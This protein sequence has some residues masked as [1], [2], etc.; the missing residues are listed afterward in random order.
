MVFLGIFFVVFITFL[1]VVH[2]F[3]ISIDTFSEP[4]ESPFIIPERYISYVT[5]IFVYWAGF[6][7]WIFT[8]PVR[9]LIGRF[10]ASQNS[11]VA[12]AAKSFIGGMMVTAYI[13]TGI[14]ILA[15][16]GLAL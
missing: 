3:L 14:S 16:L 6:V 4:H 12:L 13:A 11:S 8:L 5:F 2:A 7:Q 1:S 15:T 9:L 10:R